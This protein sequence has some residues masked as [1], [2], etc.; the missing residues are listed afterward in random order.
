M[1]NYNHQTFDLAKILDAYLFFL[2]FILVE[3]ILSIVVV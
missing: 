1:K 3:W 2:E